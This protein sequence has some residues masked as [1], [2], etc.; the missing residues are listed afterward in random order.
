VKSFRFDIGWVYI[1][2]GLLM[3]IVAIVFPSMIELDHLSSQAND[4]NQQLLERKV[5][6]DSYSSFYDELKSE[7]ETINKRVRQIQFNENAEGTPIV[8]DLAASRTPLQWIDEKVLAV[9]PFEVKTRK[10]TFLTRIVAG[11]G[12]LWIAALGVFFTFIGCLK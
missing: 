8:T 2:A 12:R 5:M 6:F 1:V 10:E 3:V 11:S 7:D 9:M 4:S